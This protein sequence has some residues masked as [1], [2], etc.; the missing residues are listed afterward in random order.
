VQLAVWLKLLAQWFV[1]L[2]KFAIVFIL[3]LGQ[4]IELLE[5]ATVHSPQP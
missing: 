2:G 4:L 5:G 1:A 3:A